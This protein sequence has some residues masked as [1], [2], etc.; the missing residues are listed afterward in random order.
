MVHGLNEG[1]IAPTETEWRPF[2]RR[3]FLYFVQEIFIKISLKFVSKS[4]IDNKSALIHLM[5]WCRTG[6]MQ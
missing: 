5:I 2:Y 4:S 6:D 3:V 1:H